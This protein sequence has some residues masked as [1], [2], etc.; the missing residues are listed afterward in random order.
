[1][2]LEWLAVLE[3]FHMMYEKMPTSAEKGTITQKQHRRAIYQIFL[4]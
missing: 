4:I 1:M 3:G 2:L